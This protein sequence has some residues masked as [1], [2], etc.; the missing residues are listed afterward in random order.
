MPSA[1]PPLLRAALLVVCLAAAASAAFPAVKCSTTQTERQNNGEIYLLSNA[2]MRIMTF[3]YA[4][5]V[6]LHC[7]R[8]EGFDSSCP[9]TLLRTSICRIDEG[10]QKQ[11][12]EPLHWYDVDNTEAVTVA[13]SDRGVWELYVDGT[14]MPAACFPRGLRASVVYDY[15]DPVYGA[16]KGGNSKYALGFVITVICLVALCIL[17]FLGRRFIWVIVKPRAQAAY[18][19]E[20]TKVPSEHV[21]PLLPTPV[22]SATRGG[23]SVLERESLAEDPRGAGASFATAG[24]GGGAGVAGGPLPF[25]STAAASTILPPIGTATSAGTSL[26]LPSGPSVDYLEASHVT[27]TT[28]MGTMTPVDYQYMV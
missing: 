28:G 1:S 2:N 19:G 3:P 5:S 26:H 13:S 11:D 14:R 18:E 21:R 15:Y 25:G 27:G 10:G 8:W 12:C 7:R 17:A 4:T 20:T 16:N 23:S 22:H 24:G 9:L 6:K